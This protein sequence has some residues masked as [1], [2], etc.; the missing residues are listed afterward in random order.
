MQPTMNCVR[1]IDC[2]LL[3]LWPWTSGFIL[4]SLSFLYILKGTNNHASLAKD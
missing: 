4:L 1:H 2:N 3:V